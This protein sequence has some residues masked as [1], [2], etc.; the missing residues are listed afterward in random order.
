VL[1][2]ANG[3]LEADARRKHM[4][5]LQRMLQDD[6]VIAQPLWRSVF[7]ASNARVQGYRLH[8]AHY[9]QLGGV[10]MG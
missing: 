4:A 3:T 6:A 8:P 7:A 2:A 5:T 1:D 10:W 9:H